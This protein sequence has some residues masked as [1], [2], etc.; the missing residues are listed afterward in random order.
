MSADRESLWQSLPCG[1]KASACDTGWRIEAEAFLCDSRHKQGQVAEG[2]FGEWRISEPPAPGM[3]WPEAWRYIREEHPDNAEHHSSCSWVQTNRAL[4]C[5]CDV[6]WDE[7]VRR[8]GTD[9][10]V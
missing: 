1:C 6:L 8:G 10:R 9:P 3:D 4:L 7:Y 5:D 2:S